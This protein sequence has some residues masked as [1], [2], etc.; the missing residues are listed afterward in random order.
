MRAKIIW[1]LISAL[2]LWFVINLLCWVGFHS[3]RSFTLDLAMLRY[4]APRMALSDRVLFLTLIVMAIAVVLRVTF[5]PASRRGC[6][7][8]KCAL[9]L[10]CPLIAMMV[11]GLFN[12]NY[13]LGYPGDMVEF[14]L[15]LVGVEYVFDET[16]ATMYEIITQSL[17]GYTHGHIF[18]GPFYGIAVLCVVLMALE[19]RMPEKPVEGCR[20]CGYNLTGNVSGICP[21]CGVPVPEEEK[22]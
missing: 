3:R 20:N 7:L 13:C 1:F 22:A 11:G 9:V 18:L 17:P 8:R 15:T 4:L 16:H 12:L 6:V 5:P 14:R 2:V 10:C 19:R 21:E